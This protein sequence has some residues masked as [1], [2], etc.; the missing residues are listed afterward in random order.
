MKGGLNKMWRNLVATKSNSDFE[1]V[2]FFKLLI[3]LK[4]LIKATYHLDSK[5]P[6]EKHVLCKFIVLID[7]RHH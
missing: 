6:K 2:F 4:R 7:I 5:E 1:K 3:F